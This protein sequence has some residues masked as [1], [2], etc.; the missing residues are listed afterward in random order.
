MSA[1]KKQHI[2][3]HSAHAP[4]HPIRSGRGFGWRF[5]SRSAVA[6]QFPV[7]ALPMNVG[8]IATLVIAIVP[9]DQV[10][11]DFSDSSKASQLARAPGTLQ[12][13]GKYLR[14]SQSTQPFLESSRIA[15]ATFCQRQVRKS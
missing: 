15:L 8:T 5:P 9:F 14:K 7:R 1:R 4:H 10:A 3:R 6:E 11:V 12:R 2:S 13:A